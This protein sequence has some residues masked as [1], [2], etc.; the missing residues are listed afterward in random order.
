MGTGQGPDPG[1]REP[2]GRRLS[3]RR[4]LGLRE[5]DLET[6]LARPTDVGVLDPG[7]GLR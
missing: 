6:G 5:R 1:Q 4:A 7:A 2:M 3:A